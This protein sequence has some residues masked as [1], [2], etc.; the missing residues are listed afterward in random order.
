MKRE[1][2]DF[3]V[4]R[5]TIDTTQFRNFVESI[6]IGKT[7]EAY[8]LNRE[9][10]F[11]TQ[12][13][14]GCDLMALDP[15][16]G[17]KLRFH[18]GVRTFKE[19]DRQG[20]RFLYATTWLSKR[21]WV[22]VVRQETAEAYEDLR[23]VSI[24]A[25]I[26]TVLGGL[27]IVLVAFEVTKRMVNRLEKLDADR[28]SLG[29]QLVVAGRL[30]EIGEM[31]AGFAHEINNPLQIMKSEMTLAETILA[32]MIERGELAE[33]EDL[34]QIKDSLNQLKIQIDRCGGITQGLLKFARKKES[35]IGAVD[36]EKFL[37]G[38]IGLVERKAKVEGIAIKRVFGAD[39]PKV[40]ADPVHL[41]QVMVNLLNNAI[42]AIVD[43][44]GS[45]GGNIVIAAERE[46]EARVRLDVADDG[47]GI[48]S[49][50][51]D[52]LFTPFFTTKPVGKGTGLGL[53][54]CY[55]IVTEMGGQMR[56]SSDEGRG[57]T[58]SILLN[59]DI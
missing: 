45:A 3:W 38:V 32:E 25:L 16:I 59:I 18:N 13:R 26:V 12:R 46:G 4:L 1:G 23:T 21:D 14:S 17:G 20:D 11:Q 43:K 9:G 36:L 39:L 8:I 22:L 31:S 7:G 42:Y 6:R 27:F 10:L 44:R 54:V 34:D 19:K 51:M 2:N 56:V 30:A 57:A 53:S 52:K 29:R 50:N 5:A 47:G 49:E 15:D 37:P 28:K 55:G 58:F 48:N 35:R 24:Y 40:H 33:S 41:E